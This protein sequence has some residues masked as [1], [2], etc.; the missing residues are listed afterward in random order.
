MG[1]ERHVLLEHP[2]DPPA[3]AGD[4]HP[5]RAD[6]QKFHVGRYRLEGRDPNA[7]EGSPD[8]IEGLKSTSVN[9]SLFETSHQGI[10]CKACA[11]V[12]VRGPSGGGG[13]P[14]LELL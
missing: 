4:Q 7:H 6:A 12:D 9:A 14:A 2:P 10:G 5:A 13:T 11:K 3:G 8:I 1:R